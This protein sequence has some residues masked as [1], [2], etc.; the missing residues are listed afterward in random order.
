MQPILWLSV[1]LTSLPNE[2]VLLTC[3]HAY[4]ELQDEQIQ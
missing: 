1:S 3:A 2:L 4:D